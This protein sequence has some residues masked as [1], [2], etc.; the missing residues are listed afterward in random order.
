MKPGCTRSLVQELLLSTINLISSFDKPGL[1]PAIYP[2][3]KPPGY[4]APTPIQKSTLS[5]IHLE[6]GT[7][8][9]GQGVTS[10]QV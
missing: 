2:N 1:Y 10:K 9:S 7:L 4:E 8:P 5:T 6:Y 3:V